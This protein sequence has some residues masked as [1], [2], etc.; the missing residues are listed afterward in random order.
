MADD[1][2]QRITQQRK[3][4]DTYSI[5]EQ[6]EETVAKNKTKS[7][8]TTLVTQKTISRHVPCHLMM[9]TGLPIK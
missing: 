3:N 9:L 8:S 2:L 4:A 6:W 7:A 1:E 5:A